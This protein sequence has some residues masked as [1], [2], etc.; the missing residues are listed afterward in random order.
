MYYTNQLLNLD[1]ILRF[2]LVSNCSPV[3]K[4]TELCRISESCVMVSC[5]G[6]YLDKILRHPAA[7][8][9]VHLHPYVNVDIRIR[10]ITKYEFV[11]QNG[12]LMCSKKI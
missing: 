10:D 12:L 6:C 8:R 5:F 3:K 4:V 1:Q 7:A 2:C 11:I 9:L